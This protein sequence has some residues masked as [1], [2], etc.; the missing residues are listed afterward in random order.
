[1][2]R[3]VNFFDMIILHQFSWQQFL[4]GALLLTFSWY[5]FIGVLYFRKETVALFSGKQ[6]AGVRKLAGV[7]D[8][9]RLVL[10]DGDD[11]GLL[12]AAREP[13]GINTVA[14]NEFSFAGAGHTRAAEEVSEED[15]RGIQLGLVPDLMEELKTIFYRLER[16]GGGR[17]DF[18]ALFEPVAAKFEPVITSPA[19]S[20]V[21]AFILDNVP[22]ALSEAELK[23]MWEV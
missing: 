21:N 23:A 3:R 8:G 13:E 11:D 19:Y 2:G 17:E 20:A 10:E 15:L 12:G 16:D 22:F 14:M 4:I 9:K 7:V 6:R 5:V 18:V 1:M